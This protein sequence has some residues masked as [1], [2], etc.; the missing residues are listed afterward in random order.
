MPRCGTWVGKDS[1]LSDAYG[2]YF[3]EFEEW[4]L[5]MLVVTKPD[6]LAFESP[7]LLQRQKGRGTDEQQVRRL[8]GVVSV[9]EKV[10]Y[11]RNIRCE[12]A[13]NQTSKAFMGVSGRR[14]EGMTKGEYKDQMLLAMVN[15]GYACADSHQADSCAIALVVYSMLGEEA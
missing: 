2:S 4:L 14:P 8:V 7:I 12:E 11:Q 13:H 1:W 3:A 9:A 15:R 6:I 10:A 5:G